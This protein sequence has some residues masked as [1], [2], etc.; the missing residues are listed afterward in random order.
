MIGEHMAST[1]DTSDDLAGQAAVAGRAEVMPHNVSDE[2]L[3]RAREKPRNG[4]FRHCILSC[5]SGL[6]SLSYFSKVLHAGKKWK[7]WKPGLWG[8]LKDFLMSPYFKA[9]AQL[10]SGTFLIGHACLRQCLVPQCR[11]LYDRALQ[12]TK[13][14]CQGACLNASD[15]RRLRCNLFCTGQFV[16]C[17]FIF[18]NELSFTLSCLASIFF[19]IG[20]LLIFPSALCC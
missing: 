12:M 6:V 20:M 2:K 11:L 16:I 8:R 5:R 1:H 3:I 9:C 14:R 19:Y 18:V 7:K 13:H 4:A 17:M 10:A 15:S